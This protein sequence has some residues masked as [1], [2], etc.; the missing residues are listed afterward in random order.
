[1]LWL[2]SSLSNLDPGALR[3]R[4]GPTAPSR[5]GTILCTP[6]L[7]FRTD[8]CPVVAGHLSHCAAEDFR[9]RRAFDVPV[10][11][12]ISNLRFT[13]QSIETSAERV[14]PRQATLFGNAIELLVKR[15][16]GMQPHRDRKIVCRFLFLQ[17]RIHRSSISSSLV[18]A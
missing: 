6:P 12:R 9:L 18:A 13:K 14:V 7:L 2:F 10:Q 11:S 1:A 5:P 16:G 17:I 4:L 15:F 8:A 3:L